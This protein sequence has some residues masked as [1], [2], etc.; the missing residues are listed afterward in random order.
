MAEENTEKEITEKENTEKVE[1]TT[2][3]KTTEN[4]LLE[5]SKHFKE[6]IEQKETLLNIMKD[7][8][9]VTKKT[10]ARCYGLIIELQEYLDDITNILYNSDPDEGDIIIEFLTNSIRTICSNVLFKS[11][12]I[13]LSLED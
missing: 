4:Q 5:M 11:E 13:E 9:I 12:V 7:K 6:L 1:E 3:N 10:I 8:Y 2:E